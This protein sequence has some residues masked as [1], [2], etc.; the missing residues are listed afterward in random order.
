MDLTRPQILKQFDL[1]QK[2]L[3]RIIGHL[4][5]AFFSRGGRRFLEITD[6]N[7]FV[8]Q[9]ARNLVDSFGYGSVSKGKIRG[10]RTLPFHRFLVLRFLN[11]PVE[12]VL[13]EVRQLGLV[14]EKNL[15]LTEMRRIQSRIFKRLPDELRPI[16][17]SRREP[18]EEEMP[19]FVLFLKVMNIR[20]FYEKPEAIDDLA[21]FI[22]MREAIEVFLATESDH[23]E[24]ASFLSHQMGMKISFKAV[25]AYRSLFFASHEM[26]QEDLESYLLMVPPTERRMKKAS[27]QRTITQIAISSGLDGACETREIMEEM[28][29]GAQKQYFNAV[30][31]KTT[32]AVQIQRAA[33]DQ[34][35]KLDE[36]LEKKGGDVAGIAKLFQK[37]EIESVPH[38]VKSIEEVRNVGRKAA[39][40]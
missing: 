30:R 39:E 8:L 21:P 14:P 35:L 23:K 10:I 6:H 5:T 31:L 25:Y 7:R 15:S 11:T 9:S 17:K 2:T 13:D 40:K 33:V 32:D 1:R 16:A 3:S 29:K 37:F 27:M 24:I 12:E 38:G 22:S 4:D 26:S 36:H 19:K 18:T 20:A 34:F 28:R